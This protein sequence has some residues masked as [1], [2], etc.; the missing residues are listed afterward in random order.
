MP[1]LRKQKKRKETTKLPH[2]EEQT[3]TVGVTI[4]F[5]EENIKYNMNKKNSVDQHKGEK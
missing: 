4:T 1:K 3:A 5:K 2:K